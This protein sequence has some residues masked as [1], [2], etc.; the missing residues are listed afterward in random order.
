MIYNAPVRDMMFLVEEWIGMDRISAIPGFGEV[1]ADLFRFVLDEAGKFA[2][3][4]LLPINRQGDEVGAVLADGEVVTPP[5][6]RDAYRKFFEN[7]WGGLDADPEHG[8]QGLPRLLQLLVDEIIGSC[9][10]GFKLYTELNRGVYHL[11]KEKAP[12]EIRELCLPKLVAGTWSG[13]MCLTEPQA[14][15]DLGLLTTKAADNGDG[16]FAITG[17]K[18]FITSGDHDLTENILHMVLARLED[19]PPGVRGISLFLVPK[20]LV[21]EDGTP[22]GRNAVRTASIEHKMGIK[23]S[24]TCVLNFDGATG[25]LVGAANRGLNAMFRMM[26]LERVAV[27]VQGLGV[28]EFAYQN[29]LAYAWERAQSRAPEPRPDG[30][31]AADPIIYQPDIRHK[32]LKMRAQVEGARALVAL[33]GFNA[34]RMLRSADGRQREEAEDFITLLTPVIKSFLSDLG[35]RSALEGQQVFGGH[36]YIREHGMEQLVRDARITQIYEGTN[37]VQA[38]DLVT[39]KLTLHGGRPVHR[40][41]EKWDA[42][43]EARSGNPALRRWTEP[44]Q[45]AFDRLREATEWVTA[46]LEVDEA[47]VLGAATDYQRLFGLT[48]VGCIWAELAAAVEGKDGAF[49][50][51]KRDLADVYMSLVLPESAF[52]LEVVTGGAESLARFPAGRLEA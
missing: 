51:D 36:G 7:G 9:C 16:T 1:D 31:R 10:M 12:A 35:V 5:G 40:Y 49:Y 45:R 32:L 33:A 50:A 29:A 23:A 52:L 20:R 22:G 28:A 38:V 4:E 6:F 14:G 19:A 15:T 47:A 43:F 18:I 8:G 25:Y 34:D 3:L 39:R 26:N 11:M 46:Q 44:A 27:G 37:E 17:T 21:N 24:A 13:T 30:G 2:S 48:T 41:F 42:F